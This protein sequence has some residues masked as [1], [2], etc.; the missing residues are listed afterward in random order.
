MMNRNADGLGWLREMRRQIA[1]ECGSPKSMGDYFRGFRKQY[2]ERIVR[3]TAFADAE[4]LY[5]RK[6]A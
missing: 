3:N 1:R 2:E 6:A 5:G 4:E